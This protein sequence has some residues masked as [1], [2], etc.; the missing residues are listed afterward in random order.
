MNLGI[1]KW[2]G[3]A[4]IP[5]EYDDLGRSYDKRPSTKSHIL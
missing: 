2:S 3:L 4:I 5:G 1:Q